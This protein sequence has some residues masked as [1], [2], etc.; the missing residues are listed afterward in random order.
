M[1]PAQQAFTLVGVAWVGWRRSQVQLPPE[2]LGGQ[3]RD[4][5]DL[6]EEQVAG[7]AWLCLAC[8]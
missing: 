4:P 7:D 5:A 3:R 6:G 2:S 8:P 1:S